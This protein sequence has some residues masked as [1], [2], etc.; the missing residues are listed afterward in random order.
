[1]SWIFLPAIA[2][3]YLRNGMTVTTADVTFCTSAVLSFEQITSSS[4][5]DIRIGEHFSD[6]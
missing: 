2:E 1:M 4:A 6:T 3:N 5:V